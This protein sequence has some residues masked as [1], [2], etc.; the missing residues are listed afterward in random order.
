MKYIQ[1]L[2]WPGIMALIV[3]LAL[4]LSAH[5]SGFIFHWEPFVVDNNLLLSSD[6]KKLFIQTFSAFDSAISASDDYMDKFEIPSYPE[7]SATQSPKNK[8]I[9]E[10]IKIKFSLAY[11]HGNN[12][13]PVHA[14]GDDEN[15]SNF[16]D[17]L[18]SLIYDPKFKSL[19][20]IGKIVEP[21]INFYFEF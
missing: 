12:K 21:Q 18:T 3:C 7:R 13:S 8:L 20:T 5:A 10:N 15:I 9:A 6:G 19:E 17:A 4:T 1:K 16:I 2:A 11:G 14:D